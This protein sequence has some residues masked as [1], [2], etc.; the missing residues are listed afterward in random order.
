MKIFPLL[1]FALSLTACSNL[2]VHREPAIDLV[3]LKKIYVEHRLADGR[4]VDQLVTQELQ[5]LG[6]D[7]SCGPLT[8]MPNHVDAV[9]SYIDQ[10]NWDFSLYMIELEIEVTDPRTNKILATSHYFHP[11]T[12]KS[13]RAMVQMVIDSLF[14][15]S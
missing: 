11:V 7:V 15:R 4:G 9:I 2:N 6:Y 10:W 13:P 8:M 5:R 14:R 3:G 1:V 12:G